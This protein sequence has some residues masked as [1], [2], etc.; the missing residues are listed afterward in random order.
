MISFLQ[1]KFGNISIARKLY[2]TV[3]IMALAVTVELCTLWFSINTLSSVR[4]FVNGEGLWSKAQK[5]AVYSLLVYAHSHDEKDYQSFL[6]FLKVP[7]GDNK[8]RLELQKPHPDM[9]IA[10]EGFLEGRNS[11]EDVGGM[12]SL[13]RRFHD[14]SYLHKAIIIW[15][16]AEKNME[17]LIAISN[18]LHVMIS[19]GKA[20]QHEIDN[21]L[22]QAEGLNRSFTKLEDDFSFTLGEG[23]RWLERVVLRILLTLSLTIGSTGILIAISVSRGI[24]RGVNAII[25]GALQV[26]RGLLST[27]VKVYSRDEIGMLAA[28]FNDMTDKLERNIRDIREL[29]DTEQNLKRE[30]E[31]A[32]TSE[33][34]KQLFLAKMSHEIR[35]PMNAI[36]G[37]ARLLE[38]TLHEKDQQD[39]IDIIIRSSED[40]LV[41]LNDILDFSRLESGKIVFE[42]I[43]IKPAE[44]VKA[45]VIMMEQKSRQ[46]G[47]DIRYLV[48]DK[49]PDTII[50]DSVRLSQVLLNL[51]SNALKFT[52]KGEIV[53][54][55]SLLDEN[56]VSVWLDFG[57]KD[58][59]IGIPAEMQEKIFESFEQ[60]SYDTA[61][62]YGGSGLGLSIVK[63]IVQLQH[64][65]LFVESKPGYGADFHFRLNFL[66]FSEPFE[67]VK[68]A[69]AENP[70]PRGEGTKILIVEDN[71]INQMLVRKV[72]GKQ[73]FETDSAENG[74]AA[75][76]KIDQSHYDLILMDLQMPEMD[77]YEATRRIR[78]SSVRRQVPI[79]AMSAHTFKDEYERCIAAGMDGFVSKPFDTIKLFDTIFGILKKDYYGR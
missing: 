11:P 34:T 64:G 47:V 16:E 1:R 31:K 15:G 8:T 62:K 13:I 21:T 58:T 7:I 53:I 46:K 57:V 77:G 32:E 12:I 79:V 14:E 37:F 25:E 39:Y 33:K 2:F 22:A 75:L 20:S 18:T 43:P 76:D 66:K 28:S 70:F 74:K 6:H 59:G 23:S 4:A 48:D 42:N 67:N 41:I 44:I 29:K 71:L 19:S 27:R 40:L 65:E 3:G 30:K 5:D 36:L 50:G 24:G 55:V 68:A 9:A 73:G 35:T 38:E 10:R 17:Q 60:A 56:D 26:S 54:S 52:E 63:Q 49:V 78:E 69:A 72:L 51:V 45:T 61:R